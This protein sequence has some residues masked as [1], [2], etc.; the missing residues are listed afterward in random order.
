MVPHFKPWINCKLNVWIL[1]G[2]EL[3][4]KVPW[5]SWFLIQQWLGELQNLNRGIVQTPFNKFIAKFFLPNLNLTSREIKRQNQ[6]EICWAHSSKKVG[7]FCLCS[8]SQMKFLN[9]FYI[10]VIL[11]YDI[12]NKILKL[13][14]L[15]HFNFWPLLASFRGHWKTFLLMLIQQWLVGRFKGL[16]KGFQSTWNESKIPTS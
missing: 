11:L 13:D 1:Q 2:A 8:L 3:E 15:G 6:S 10:L 7:F 4:T 5:K 14:C 16:M 12:Y 9:Y